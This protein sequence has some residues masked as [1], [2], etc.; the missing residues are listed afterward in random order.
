MREP[1]RG[2]ERGAYGR[3][4]RL[5]IVVLLLTLFPSAGISVPSSF[6]VGASGCDY[7]TIQQA[8]DDDS[9]PPGSTLS[10]VDPVHTEAGIVIAK[11]LAIEGLGAGISALQAHE[12]RGEAPDRV[13]TVMYGAA[14][15]LRDVTIRNGRASDDDLFRSG[16]GILNYGDL[17][18][19]RCVVAGNEA[20]NGGGI[21]SHGGTLTVDATTI[22]DNLAD[23]T[24]PPGYECGSGGGVKLEAGARLVM[25]D[26]AILSNRA[27]GKGGGLYVAC[28][29]EAE[30]VNCTV[31][32]NRASKF[33][34]GLYSRNALVLAY[35]T[36]SANAVDS[37]RAGGGIYVRGTIRMSCS[38]VSRNGSG[39]D[40]VVGGPGD[41]R[42]RGA[43]LACD[44]CLIGDSSYPAAL[45]RDPRLGELTDA[46]YS[47]RSGPA[48]GARPS[49]PVMP[50]LRGSP[51]IDAIPADAVAVGADQ[52]GAPRPAPVSEGE[53]SGDIGAFELQ[54]RE[55]YD[56][57]TD[58]GGAAA[59]IA[60]LAAA[61]ALAASAYAVARIAK[62]RRGG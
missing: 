44:Y 25:R 3:L 23:R 15:T 57:A 4:A 33:G 34:G 37:P 17:G 24:A 26:S 27:L 28:E 9:V 60:W 61:V 36:V 5:A 10:I 12:T 59:L 39:L 13:M 38:I 52:R 20:N 46:P 43:V 7:A 35:C 32:L 40:C 45:S 51:A 54:P 53:A 19:E 16:G 18:L 22:R 2:P 6:T 62:N 14:V 29:S 49:P 41:Y 31:G 11:D 58:G 50:L 56:T 21:L 1:W 42:G 48:G 8:S 55:A 30:L 47:E